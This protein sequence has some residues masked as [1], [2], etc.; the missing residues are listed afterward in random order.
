MMRERQAG[1][2][3]VTGK[4]LARGIIY[5][6]N[7]D[8]AAAEPGLRILAKKEQPFWAAHPLPV[9]VKSKGLR[10]FLKTNPSALCALRKS[11][12]RT[13]SIEDAFLAKDAYEEFGEN[14]VVRAHAKKA[15]QPAVPTTPPS[16][17]VLV[18]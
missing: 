5:Y 11:D 9:I 17:A 2:P 15:A 10:E 7:T 3:L 12:W 18:P 1:E 13:F 8:M 4:F 16:P 6:T 14:L